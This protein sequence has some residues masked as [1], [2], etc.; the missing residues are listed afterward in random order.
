MKTILNTDLD[1]KLTEN[2]TKLSSDISN[3]GTNLNS[4]VSS[5]LT[6]FWKEEVKYLTAV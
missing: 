4:D 5:N 3:K 1:N 2:I 6:A